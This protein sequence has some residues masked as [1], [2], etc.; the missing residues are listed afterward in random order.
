MKVAS[1]E[2]VMRPQMAA[3]GGYVASKAPET[4]EGKVEVAV[5]D[6]IKLDA[7]ENPYGCSPRVL[8]ALARFR[9]FSV[10]PDAGQGEL[11]KLIA[12]YAGVDAERV[13]A[14]NGSDQL[15]DYILRLFVGPGDEVINC[16][17]TFDVFRFRT[18]ICAGTMV[19]VVRDHPNHS[20]IVASPCPTPTHR[21]AS[22]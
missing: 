19:E 12:G 17:P 4:L 7:N 11:K 16:I 15:I 18:Q 3:V 6:I 22:P 20:T 8:E 21:V 10:Y 1:L 13:V 2:D 5:E 14:G 9:Y